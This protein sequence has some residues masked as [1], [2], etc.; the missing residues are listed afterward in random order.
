VNI[1]VI[2]FKGDILQEVQQEKVKAAVQWQKMRENP[3]KG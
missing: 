2:S 3:V 1:I